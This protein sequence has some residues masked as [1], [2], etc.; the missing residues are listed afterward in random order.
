M[1]TITLN[2]EETVEYAVP[3]V[4][5]KRLSGLAYSFFTGTEAN[6]KR[7][8]FQEMGVGV[9]DILAAST[10]TVLPSYLDNASVSP[11][12][13]KPLSEYSEQDY[14]EMFS[15][16]AALIGK[17]K[18]SDLEGVNTEWD[19]FKQELSK[20]YTKESDWTPS[21]KE[22]IV[23]DDVYKINLLINYL[24]KTPSVRISQIDNNDIRLL[25][26]LDELPPGV[27]GTLSERPDSKTPMDCSVAD[28]QSLWDGRVNQMDACSLS[29]WNKAKENIRNVFSLDLN[30]LP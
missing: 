23:Q 26:L 11:I 3:T 18:L 29:E 9:S 14:L 17:F 6:R 13:A 1:P 15:Q 21:L 19:E 12:P 27:T 30:P 28:F 4:K 5:M 22:I 16:R 25:Y 8:K 2:S 10:I 24:Y 7:F 20:E